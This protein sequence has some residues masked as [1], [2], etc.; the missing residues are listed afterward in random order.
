MKRRSLRTLAIAIA[1]AFVVVIVAM[2]TAALLRSRPVRLPQPTGPYLVGRTEW[3]LDDSNRNEPGAVNRASRAIVIHAT[4]PTLDKGEPGPYMSGAVARLRIQEHAPAQLL[5]SDPIVVRTNS[6]DGATPA[7][8]EITSIVVFLPGAGQNVAEYTGLIEDLA[9]HGALVVAV[10]PP[11]NA[12]EMD[13]SGRVSPAVAAVYSAPEQ[14]APFRAWA[15]AQTSDWALDAGLAYQN[16]LAEL[17]LDRSPPRG[18][19]AVGHSLGGAAAM[20][21]CAK[22]AECFGAIDIDG[23]PFGDVTTTGLHKPLL[24]MESDPGQD[25]NSLCERANREWT[26]IVSTASPNGVHKIFR[27]F[28]HFDFT[29]HSLFYDPALHWAGVLGS[30]PGSVTLTTTRASVKDFVRRWSSLN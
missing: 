24:V 10:A 3:R 23:W 20:E 1:A 21:V 15:D 18:F 14:E 9:S 7:R 4:Y 28:R 25:C 26:F 22:V 5:F 8:A 6:L 19:I 29:D 17:G 11:G 30:T 13:P 16:A 12:P 2:G 27:D